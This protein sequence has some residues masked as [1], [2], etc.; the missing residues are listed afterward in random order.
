MAVLRKRNITIVPDNNK[1]VFHA[2]NDI[3][4][5]GGGLVSAVAD[6]WHY[7]YLQVFKITLALITYQ[8]FR[9]SCYLFA[10]SNG[11][12]KIRTFPKIY[13][14]TMKY[15]AGY[16]T[17]SN[18]REQLLVLGWVLK[19]NERRSHIICYKFRY[20]HRSHTSCNVAI[21][22]STTSTTGSKHS[23]IIMIGYDAFE[24]SFLP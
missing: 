24:P 10:H 22:T 19:N 18:D 20:N 7:Q 3:C 6:N 23:I 2:L 4:S 9:T 1:S 17:W 11:T 14:N 15:V 21:S 16:L 8:L 13:L 12:I 5:V